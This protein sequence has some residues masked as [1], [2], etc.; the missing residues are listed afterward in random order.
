MTTCGNL[1]VLSLDK[2]YLLLQVSRV[3]YPTRSMLGVRRPHLAVCTLNNLHLFSHIEYHMLDW[4][5][6]ELNN[7]RMSDY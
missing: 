3:G 4:I 5:R 7:T 2:S 6:A 1:L